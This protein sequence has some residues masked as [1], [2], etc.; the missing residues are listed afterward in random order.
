[1]SDT[2]SLQIGFTELLYG[3]VIANV[4]DQLEFGLVLRN[5]M[6]LLAFVFILADWIE[7]QIAV[8]EV[9]KE[10]SNY[11]VAFVLD[12]VILI[13]WYY[14]TIVPVSA[15]DWF[16]AIAGGFFF[17]Q[18][19]WDWFLMDMEL[20][21]LVTKP[22]LQLTAVFILFSAL[23]RYVAVESTIL[24]ATATIAF[25]VLKLPEWRAILRNSPEAI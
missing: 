7:Y 15:L 13:V 22:Q 18:A 9:P 2:E 21:S 4:I 19:T 12:V 25:L 16:F 17:L 11:I 1:M 3:V 23:H 24:L 5:Y 6:I 14:L 20:R 10:R 8:E